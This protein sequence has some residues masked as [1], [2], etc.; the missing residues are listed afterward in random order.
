MHLLDPIELRFNRKVRCQ[1]HLKCGKGG[2]G[3]GLKVTLCDL[4][5]C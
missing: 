2:G 4:T 1:T 3:V 5:K